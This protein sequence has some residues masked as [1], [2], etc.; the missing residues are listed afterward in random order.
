MKSTLAGNA[1]AG[2]ANGMA[3]SRAMRG[4]FQKEDAL[5]SAPMKLDIGMT[6]TSE[7]GGGDDLQ[8]PSRTED[9]SKTIEDG[10]SFRH[11]EPIGGR[12]EN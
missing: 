2:A 3:A 4:F 6:G 9:S 5:S 8:K 10:R 7:L 11:R 12:L 1:E